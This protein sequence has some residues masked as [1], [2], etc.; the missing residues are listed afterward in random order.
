[1]ASRTCGK[2]LA[3]PGMEQQRLVVDDQVLVEREPAGAGNVDRRVDAEDAVG[4]F[5]DRGRVA[6]VDGVM[7]R[8]FALDK[9]SGGCVTA[10]EGCA[11]SP[12]ATAAAASDSHWSLSAS[13]SSGNQEWTRA[14]R[15]ARTAASPREGRERPPGRSAPDAPRRSG[16]D[17]R[18][19]R[20]S[21]A[22]RAPTS[23]A[24]AR[25]SGGAQPCVRARAREAFG[26]RRRRLRK[27][28][29]QAAARARRHGRRRRRTRQSSE[30]K[31][32]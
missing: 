7:L 29:V 18:R 30:G 6:D 24:R 26:A 14:G 23:A 28:R 21:A 25:S 22:P 3:R 2:R 15:A 8:S 19:A 11:A 17:A 31:C 4:D 1:M 27:S 9:G 20:G 13:A 12:I 32:L 16:G 10:E 5:V